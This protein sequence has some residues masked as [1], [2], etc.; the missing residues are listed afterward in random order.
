MTIV[1]FHN[2]RFTTVNFLMHIIVPSFF[3][4]IINITVR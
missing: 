1:G 2:I 3:S 4:L